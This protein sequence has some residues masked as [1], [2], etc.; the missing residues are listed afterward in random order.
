[1]NKLRK[2]P[3]LFI[4]EIV[5]LSLVLSSCNN[6]TAPPSPSATL[7]P[8]ATPSMNASVS[9]SEIGSTWVRPADG[10]IMVYVPEGDFTMG[11]TNA[12]WV[13]PVHKVTLDAY[14]IDQTEVTNA[15]YE[16]C[17]QAGACQNPGVTKSL[18]RQTY[19][20]DPQYDSYPVIMVRWDDA[21]AYCTWAGARLP[22]EAE[23]E[24]A[25]R[26]P[27]GNSWPWVYY[28]T[29]N[30]LEN[31]NNNYGDTKAVGSY[32]DGV[33]PYGAL[34]MAGNVAEYVSDWWSDTYNNSPAFNPQGPS[35]G[36][37]KIYRGG[38][39]ADPDYM[40]KPSWR[41][42]SDPLAGSWNIGFRCAASANASVAG[43]P[44]TTLGQMTAAD[45]FKRC[46]TADEVADVNSKLVLTF[47][48]DPTAGT[49]VC[50]TADG[51]A[52]LTL[53]QKHAYQAIII[54]KYLQFDQPLPWTDKQ[55]YDWFTSAVSGINF[56]YSEG[57]SQCCV[58]GMIIA[59]VQDDTFIMTQNVW[60]NG[61]KGPEITGETG[62]GAS[63]GPGLMDTTGLF[64]HEAR[65]NEGDRH[66]HLCKP[67]NGTFINDLHL[68]DMDAYGVQY[69]FFLWMAQH[70]D[71]AFLKAPGSDPN[72]YR[73]TAMYDAYMILKYHFCNDPTPTPGPMPTVMP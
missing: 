58:N 69:Y 7:S 66:L 25:A 9:S 10:M 60:A 39:Y 17:V 36:Q 6:T 50:K 16:K 46:P 21:D 44:T 19:Y 8:S 26:G 31:Y 18:T 37:Y 43:S 28:S 1:M 11:G 68:A 57:D 73:E 5:I 41:N 20:G 27:D 64:V 23:W 48:N 45:F 12:S 13:K 3:C 38:S 30:H 42:S 15:M 70:G 52:D 55:L 49:L 67:I 35:T 40:T 14:W 72:A 34:D 61:V 56:D 59:K 2:A 54:M 29:S 62:L 33:S 51:S 22:T 32:P 71:P 24:K 53:L 63:W 65:H 47:P 4:A